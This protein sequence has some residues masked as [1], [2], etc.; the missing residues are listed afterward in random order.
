MPPFMEDQRALNAL[1]RIE[2]A[3]A[4]IEAAAARGGGGG[5]SDKA[6]LDA[7]RAAHGRLKGRVERA[8]SDIDDLLAQ[9]G[10]ATG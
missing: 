6:E 2:R 7:L 10:E 5:G 4:Q 1:A 8:I 3:V 9:R